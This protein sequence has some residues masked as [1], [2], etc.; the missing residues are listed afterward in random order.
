V[1]RRGVQPLAY[2]PYGALD[3]VDHIVVDGAGQ[4]STVLTLSHW[5]HSGTPAEL[6][7]DL[8]AEIAFRYLDQP[9]FHVDAQAVTNNH[10]DQ[11]GLVSVYALTDPDDALRRREQLVDVARAGDFGKFRERSSA[12]AGF[13]IAQLGAELDTDPYPE[14]LER[15]GEILDHPDRYAAYWES[16][17]AHLRASEDAI[18]SG[19]VTIEELPEVD[20]A[21]VQVPEDLPALTAHRFSRTTSQVVHHMAVHNATDRLRI[22]YVQGRRYELQYLYETWIQ[23]ASFRPMPRVDLAGLVEQLDELESSGGR[24]SFSG[25]GDIAPTLQLRDADESSIT[26]ERFR[27]LLVDALRTGAPA[28]NPYG[29]GDDD[30]A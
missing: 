20:L 28:W 8:S 24:W 3:S 25:A 10:F 22:L 23:L 2:S 26:P 19:A 15:L 12:A 14:I 21:V 4:P 27:S 7:A 29:G 1:Y 11:D 18:A 30:T 16:E 13:T 5:P 9:A 17:D 6:R